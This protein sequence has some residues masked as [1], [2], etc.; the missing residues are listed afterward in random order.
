MRSWWPVMKSYRDSPPCPQLFS[1]YSNRIL[2]LHH[3]LSSFTRFE[4]SQLPFHFLSIASPHWFMGKTIDMSTRQVYSAMLL[5]SAGC[6]HPAG[7]QAGDPFVVCRSDGS[8]IT[9]ASPSLQ[10]SLI[11]STAMA[12]VSFFALSPYGHICS[13]YQLEMFYGENQYHSLLS[14]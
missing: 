9:Q 6:L 5:P 10:N 3:Q 1:S 7:R 4:D 12:F 2:G 14:L 13:L 11:V 8:G